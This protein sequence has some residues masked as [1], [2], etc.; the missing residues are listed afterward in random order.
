MDPRIYYVVHVAA[1]VLLTAF[2]F[3]MFALPD[4]ERRRKQMMSTGIL[5]LLVLVAGFGLL[6]KMHL[7]FSGWV[8]VKLVAWLGLAGMGGVAARRPELARPLSLVATV[9]VIAAVWAVY[10]KPF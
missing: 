4:P 7:A 3:Q 6:A 5:S 10:F 1:V 8:V 2:T 9:L